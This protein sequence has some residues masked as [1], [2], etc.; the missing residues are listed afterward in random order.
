MELCGVTLTHPD[1]EL[2]PGVTKEDLAGY[3][4]AVADALLP[5]VAGRA[6]T[7]VRMQHGPE[8][9]RFFQKHAPK[10][11]PDW[12]E[13]ARLPAG[14]TQ[15]WTRFLTASEPRHLVWLAQQSAVELHVTTSTADAYDRPDGFVLD[16]DPPPDAAFVEAVDAALLLRTELRALG[17]DGV[18]KTS[19][20]KGLHVHVPVVRGPRVDDVRQVARYLCQRVAD[21][22]PDR[23][24]V[25]MLKADREGRTFLDYTR[26]GTAM[27][28]VAAWSPRARVGAP[29]AM[30]LRWA[31]VGP[32]LDPAAFTVTTAAARLADGDPWAGAWPEPFSLDGLPRATGPE[33][34]R[35][36]RMPRPDAG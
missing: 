32:T 2:W 28:A 30:P 26:N 18:P 35:F 22:H 7:L 1:R 17:L 9:D 31:E 8:G 21:A 29:V 11:T 12:F 3:F 15:G 10:H 23:Y 25:E 36:G 24:T 20:G 14:N 34:D 4:V 5:G 27:T 19:G 33:P 13:T 6:L 16:I